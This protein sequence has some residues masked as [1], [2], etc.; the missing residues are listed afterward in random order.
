[1]LMRLSLTNIAIIEALTV[2]FGPGLTVITGE[3]GAGKSILLDA[4]SLV[5]GAKASPK[6]VIRAGNSRAGVEL[7]FDIAVLPNRA[8]IGDFLAESGI[9]LLSGETE[10]LLS[11]EF[12]PSGSR[13]R[14]N[15]VP[16][17]REVLETLRPMV[18]DLHGQHELTSLFDRAAQRQYLDQLG[19]PELLQV[20][21]N[22][23]E[24]Y[25]SW[26]QLK[27]QL[28]TL[29][30]QQR[31]FEQRRDFLQ[32][33]LQELLDA[34]L[35]DPAEDGAAQEELKRLNHAEQL[36][37]ASES[38]SYGLSEGEGEQPAIIGQLGRLL[39]PLAD[40]AVYDVSLQTLYDRLNSATEELKE[41]AADL[42][43]YPQ[44]IE[45][46]PE[47]IQELV[48]RL[49]T[50][51]RLKRKYGPTLQQVL[52]TRETLD[53]QLAEETQAL[54][55]LGDLE[56]A[57]AQAEIRL[58][59][60]STQLTALRL[61]TATRLQTELTAQLTELCMPAVQF[62]LVF[63]PIDFT[64]DGAEMVTFLFSANPGEP[65]RPLAKVASGGELSRF[66]LALKVLTAASDGVATLVFDEIDTGISGPTAKAVA[67]KL[68]TLG[69]GLQVLVI[70]H[71]PIVAVLADR[72][73]HVRKSAEQDSVRVEVL[74]LEEEGW[75]LSILSRLV[76]GTDTPDEATERFV[77]QLLSQAADWK[78]RRS[79]AV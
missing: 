37:R 63:E 62:D 13:S 36:L 40:A 51:E 55:D 25:Q 16:V 49:D 70:T 78:A 4:L 17:P 18:V 5:F 7:L 12:S 11:R 79:L 47:R 66:L 64:A 74:A 1:M 77:R 30:R 46:R 8:A 3:T 68:A 10:I 22:V 72:H 9:E 61:Q 28:D 67:E 21:A 58:A 33:Q 44:A 52:D 43:R 60:V 15:G 23:R 14:V 29:I 20:R 45:Y 75:R 2:T 19:G 34:E 59:E 27:Q 31:E 56:T 24:A 71:Q 42:A 53:R 41:V 39:K 69:S 54:A 6:E 50:L 65:L 48:D 38:V 57:V 32:F 35:H 73:L 26:Q 76:S